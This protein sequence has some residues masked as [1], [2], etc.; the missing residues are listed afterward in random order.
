MAK[1]I[2]LTWYANGWTREDYQGLF[3]LVCQLENYDRV[4]AA[5]E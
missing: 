4:K 3:D 5:Y 1:G 2:C